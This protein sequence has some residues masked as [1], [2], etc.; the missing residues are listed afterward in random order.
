DR[1]PSVIAAIEVAKRKVLAQAYLAKRAQ[2]VARPTAAEI[3]AY[4]DEHP[5]L[6]GERAVYKLQEISIRGTSPQLAAAVKQY[7]KIKTLEEMAGWLKAAGVP[8][9]SDVSVLAAEELPGTL[10]GPVSQLRPG[11]VIKLTTSRGISILQLIGKRREALTLSKAQPAIERYL[12]NQRLGK[13]M[14]Q[15]VLRLKSKATIEYYPPFASA[16]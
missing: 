15:E 14:G 12:L 16:K 2:E 7:E 4:Y 8:H 1:E 13:Q 9:R 3:Q 6:F 10:L 11:Q 5:V